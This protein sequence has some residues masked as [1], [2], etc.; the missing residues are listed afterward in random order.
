VKVIFLDKDGVLTTLQDVYAAERHQYKFRSLKFAACEINPAR[1]K[2]L[3][4]IVAATGAV[5]VV[6]A[7][8][9]LSYTVPQ[10]R[11]IL[12]MCGF[13]GRVIDKTPHL[14][15]R[16][17]RD[18]RAWL[19]ANPGVESYVIIDDDSDM[20]QSMPRLVKT[21]LRH[22]LCAKHIAPA[23]RLLNTPCAPRPAW[24]ELTRGKNR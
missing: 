1:V 18:I 21:K 11:R 9:R 3:N 23:V 5:V 13:E 7:V 2:H 4:A 19:D 12:R 8:L 20:G 10:L 14:G 15:G 22:G 6:S 17:G 16:R 24:K